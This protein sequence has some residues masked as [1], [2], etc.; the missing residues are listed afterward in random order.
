[1]PHFPNSR[2]RTKPPT[3]LSSFDPRLRELLLQGSTGVVEVPCASRGEAIRLR[4]RFNQFRF[5]AKQH[6]GAEAPHEWEPLYRCI[7]Q[8]D[9]AKLTLR[10]RDSEFDSAL[11]G[12]GALGPTAPVLPPDFLDTITK[13][14]ES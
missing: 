9:G 13:D 7:V 4:Q 6:W 5:A 12:A 14:T 3:P 8:Q 10:P 11:S 1:M 2:G